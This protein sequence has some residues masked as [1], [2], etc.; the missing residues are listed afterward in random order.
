MCQ[1]DWFMRCPDC[2]S[3]T[4]LGVSVRMFWDEINIQMIEWVKQI[5]FQSVTSLNRTKRLTFFRIRENSSC[6]TAF[7]LGH[8]LFQLWASN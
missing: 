8:W 1:L 5:A 7:E 6:L 2:W 3:N 4:I